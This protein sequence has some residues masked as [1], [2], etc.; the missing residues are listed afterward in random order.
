LLRA[1]LITELAQPASIVTAS[2]TIRI[3][4]AIAH[5]EKADCITV[6]QRF[7]LLY[8]IYTATSRDDSRTLSRQYR[9]T[10]I[11]EVS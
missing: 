7:V 4:I 11:Q 1:S 6:A 3:R 2:A 8:C 10:F 9:R 5:R